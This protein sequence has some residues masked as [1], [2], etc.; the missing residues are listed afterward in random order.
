MIDPGA[1]RS[2]LARAAAFLTRLPVRGDG[3]R[4]ADA[5]WAFPLVGAGLGLAAGVVFALGAAL[6]LGP[7]PA[8]LLAV[9]TGI[10]LTGALHE[11]GLA[12]A[13]DGLGARGG[14]A[15]RLAAMRDSHAGVFGI[16]ALILVVLGRVAL[17]ADLD[18][19][20]TVAGA[21]MAS[22]AVG[23]AAM[24]AVMQAVPPARPEGLSAAAGRPS[25]NGAAIA[26]GLGAAAALVGAGPLA[27][28]AGLIVAGAAAWGVARLARRLL[29]GQT[30]DVLGAT[31]QLAELAFLSAVAACA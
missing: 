26:L 5:A 4:L 18:G 10:V 31:Q 3:G 16:L 8:A 2:E 11:D 12:D 13:A 7:W 1:W 14:P 27:A 19:G 30:G 25:A 6:G 24:A 29:G 22:G 20:L 21:L 28:I 17:V 15:E 23:R 9:A